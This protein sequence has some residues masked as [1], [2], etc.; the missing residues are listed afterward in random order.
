MTIY[1]LNY[2]QAHRKMECPKTKISITISKKRIYKRNVSLSSFNNG[3]IEAELVRRVILLLERS[4]PGDVT[5][6][7]PGVHAFITMSVVDIQLKMLVSTSLG[8]L[9]SAIN[10]ESVNLLLPGSIASRELED[11]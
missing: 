11:R 6:S 8:K 10:S 7:I 3:V 2:L 5:V 4:K 1:K 9:G